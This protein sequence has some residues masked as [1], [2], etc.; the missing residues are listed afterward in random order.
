MATSLTPS[1]VAR[2]G[3]RVLGERLHPGLPLGW[4]QRRAIAQLARDGSEAAVR[5]MAVA[6]AR[7][8]PMAEAIHENL[9]QALGT[10]TDPLQ[11][12]VIAEVAF[13]EDPEHGAAP[14][15][16][17]FKRTGGLPLRPPAARVAVALACGWPER[18]AEDWPEIVPP[19]LEVWSRHP[20][21]STATE[22]LS[23]LRHPST[24]DVL[25]RH[26]INARLVWNDTAELRLKLWL[27]LWTD[28]STDL[29]WCFAPSKPG[30]EW[31]ASIPWLFAVPFGELLQG[32][33]DAE[34]R[35]NA[36]G[37]LLLHAGHTPSQ[38]V[39]RVL[40]AVLANHPELL[41]ED[42]P[43]ILTPLLEVWGLEQ[44]QEQARHVLLGLR[45]PDTVDALCRHWIETGDAGDPLAALLLEAGHA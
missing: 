36:L 8:M 7:R 13:E 14:L 16:E 37:E 26:W 39:E 44:T 41:A 38:S 2:Y 23:Q 9:L 45:A 43:S 6:A 27:E 25:C 15:I 34:A 11:V 42:G 17:I 10:L 4:Q 21:N 18:L 35:W 24:V 29:S 20:R 40:F 31:Q 33:L 1:Q 28:E 3:A 12:Q 22:A 5:A 32:R 30:A 19:L